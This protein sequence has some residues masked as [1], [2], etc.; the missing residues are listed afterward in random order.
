MSVELFCMRYCNLGTPWDFAVLSIPSVRRNC[1]TS[2]QA[3]KYLISFPLKEVSVLSKDKVMGCAREV[4]NAIHPLAGFA[5]W[6]GP[7]VNRENSVHLL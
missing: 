2:K 4:A 5:E 7:S 3:F 1:F 6:S